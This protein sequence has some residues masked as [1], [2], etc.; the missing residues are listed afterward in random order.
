MEKRQASFLAPTGMSPEALRYMARPYERTFAVWEIPSAPQ[1][2]VDVYFTP[3]AQKTKTHK[4]VRINRLDTLNLQSPLDVIIEPDSEGYF[5]KCVD[6]PQ[7][8]GH[9]DTPLEAV[10]MLKRE[11]ESLYLDLMEDD[12]W[13]DEFLKLKKFLKLVVAA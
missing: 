6:V 2:S 13:T 9:S 3:L 8:Y 1:E 12:N 7:V 4:T 5:C 11:L 10:D